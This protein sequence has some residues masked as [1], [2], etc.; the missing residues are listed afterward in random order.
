MTEAEWEIWFHPRLSSSLMPQ[1]RGPSGKHKVPQ[2]R[3]HVTMSLTAQTRKWVCLSILSSPHPA[4]GSS[5][6]T[7]SADIQAT[8][9][10]LF[11]FLTWLSWLVPSFSLLLHTNRVNSLRWKPEIHISSPVSLFSTGVSMAWNVP[12]N[13]AQLVLRVCATS[14]SSSQMLAQ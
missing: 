7:S 14:S 4:A 12:H 2:Q 10:S 1:E 9:F 11:P 3:V 6:S 13:S 8:C 5:C